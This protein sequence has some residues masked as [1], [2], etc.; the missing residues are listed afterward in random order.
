M[1]R[2]SYAMLGLPLGLF[3]LFYVAFAIVAGSALSFTVVGLPVLAAGLRGARLLG[4]L[5][6]RLARRLLGFAG[7]GP[8]TPPTGAGF[9]DWLKTGLTDRAG[10]QAAVYLLIKAPLAVLTAGVAIFFYGYGIAGMTY[11]LWWKLVPIQDGH[12]GVPLPG[13]IYLDNWG[14]AALISSLGAGLV[15]AAPRMLRAVLLFDRLAIGALLGPGKL[16]E[17]VRE[18]EESRAFA[19]QDTATMLRRI[20]RDLHDGAQAR[21]VAVA[22]GL[23]DAKER[24]EQTNADPASR[25]L[26]SKAHQDAKAAIVELRNLARGFHPPSLDSGLDVAL[27][28]LAARNAIPVEL[29]VI[30]PRRPPLAVETI[31][32]FCV[33][34]LLTNVAKHSRARHATVAVRGERDRLRLVVSDDGQGGA[35]PSGGLVGL[36]DRARTVDGTLKVDSPPGGPTIVTVE[37]PCG[38]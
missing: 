3:G 31:A 18:L 22:M 2:F 37:L 29:S 14:R 28:T 20:E 32:Y 30:L 38:S 10:W 19:V 17:R 35:R 34:E 27:T 16:R 4:T 13:N 25:R 26:I 5:H 33:A 21:L 8:T 11:P 1:K 36:A 6:H 7:A 15:L 9:F 12:A 23:G 24:L